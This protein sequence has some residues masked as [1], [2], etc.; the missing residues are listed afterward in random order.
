MG[1]R[2]A[3]SSEARGKQGGGR[4]PGSSNDE[5][6]SAAMESE[7]RND[8]SASDVYSRDDEAKIEKRLRDLGYI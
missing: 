7:S 4:A 2:G 1:A 6:S 5:E 8:A 3:G